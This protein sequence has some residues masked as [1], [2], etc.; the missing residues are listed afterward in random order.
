[1]QIGASGEYDSTF[2]C[3]GNSVN[4]TGLLGEN[5]KEHGGLGNG[6]LPAGSRDRAPVGGLKLFRQTT[7]NICTKIQ[8]TTAVAVT[9]YK[10]LCYCRG[11]ARG[12][13]E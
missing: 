13:C 9:G 4:L 12:T 11:T 1:M 10:W 8:Q 3:T 6:S 2:S 5:I 7:H